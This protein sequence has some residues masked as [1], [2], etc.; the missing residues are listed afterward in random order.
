MEQALLV[1]H[2]ESVYSARALM[3]G[4]ASVP[5]GL[6]PAGVAQARALGAQL[7]DTPLDLA[8]TS[9]LARTV[10]TADEILRGRRVPRL[11]VPRLN[12]PLYGAYE[13]RPL[14][15][16]R[17]WA[18]SAPS[19]ASPPGGGESR[20]VLLARYVAAFRELV[21]RPE[22]AI[23]VVAHSLPIAYALEAK[24]GSAPNAHM[25]LVEYATAYHFSGE[26]LA[27]VAEAL[28]GWLTAPG[29]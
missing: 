21:G 22:P 17:A 28:A 24:A 12:D 5:V 14:E 15:E 13:G 2:G 27:A 16:Y 25:P 10:A 11:V 18:V 19:S 6:T 8:V 1:R 9:A 3:N 23:L 26:E 7:R 20:Q 4:D 29:F